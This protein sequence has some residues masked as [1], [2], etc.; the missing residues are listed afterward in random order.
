ME[1]I[2]ENSLEYQRKFRKH[3]R[4]D[5]GKIVYLA[6]DSKLK[7]PMVV[8]GF[9]TFDS[10]FDYICQWITSQRELKQNAFLDKILIDENM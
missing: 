6:S 2:D 1:E 10:E 4:F 5:V 8:I 7:C 9:Y 3:L